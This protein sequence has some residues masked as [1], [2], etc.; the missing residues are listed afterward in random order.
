MEAECIACDTYTP[1]KKGVVCNLTGA[2]G[3]SLQDV[4]TSPGFWRLTSGSD[5]IIRCEYPL[6][7]PGGGPQACT[8][9]NEGPMCAVCAESM[10]TVNDDGL[11]EDCPDGT[12][13]PLVAAG[14]ILG[15]CLI[16]W[17]I[18]K[19]VYRPSSGMQKASHRLKKFR[20]AV[21]NI[22]PSKAKSAVTF[23]QIMMSLDESFDL[24]P[25][26]SEYSDLISVFKFVEIDWSVQAYPKGCLVGGYTARLLMVA[27]APIGIL[28]AFPIALL[29]AIV[30]WM[31]VE[32]FCCSGS[33]PPP[34]TGGHPTSISSRDRRKSSVFT[35]ATQMIQIA[36]WQR[37]PSEPPSSQAIRT[38]GGD[39]KLSC[40]L[41]GRSNRDSISGSGSLAYEQVGK[42][43]TRLLSVLPMALFVIFI[44]LP[45]VS[46][47]IFAVW[48]CKPYK[49]GAS[50][51]I[52]YLRR[53]LA[54][55][56]GGNEHNRMT[57]LAVILVLVWPVGMQLFFVLA[58]WVNRKALYTGKETMSANAMK[59]LTGGYKPQ[60]FYCARLTLTLHRLA[61]AG[62]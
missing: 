2:F 53:D 4:H 1:F 50:T 43:T 21:T 46:R 44:M 22:G 37:R 42:W 58:L 36:T 57:A 17:P 26:A 49:T 14:A 56:C 13:P 10:M 47:T 32:K 45:S 3:P 19:L 38:A 12:V 25:L 61:L 27:F 11:C 6:A 52:S 8:D 31:A 29:F 20:E 40:R 59:F 30:I 51:S 24:E 15:V 62:T 55:L 28:V 35:Q 60:F 34:H 7:C 9:G 5:D 54:V 16:L 39:E 23:Y 41:S 33:G 18:R 48:D